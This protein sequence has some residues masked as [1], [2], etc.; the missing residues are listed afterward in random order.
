MNKL[1]S[2]LILGIVIGA[3]VVAGGQWAFTKYQD[4]QISDNM[5]SFLSGYE[6]ATNKPSYVADF[7]KNYDGGVSVSL[8]NSSADGGDDLDAWCW[9]VRRYLNALHVYWWDLQYSRSS[10]QEAIINGLRE[11]R[12]SIIEWEGILDEY[13][14]AAVM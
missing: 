4:K 7:R 6:K 5:T 12:A 11:T 8:S 2:R 14:S 3:V 10:D 9:D 1:T 13:C